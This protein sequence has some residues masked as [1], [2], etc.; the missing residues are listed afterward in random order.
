MNY[1]LLDIANIGVAGF[2]A[3][4]AVLL[5]LTYVLLIIVPGKS[6]YSVSYLQASHPL[7]P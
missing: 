4:T 5:F 1:S 2:S 7:R 6:A 3:I